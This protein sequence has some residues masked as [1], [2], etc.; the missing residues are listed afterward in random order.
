MEQGTLTSRSILSSFV[1]KSF[2][3]DYSKIKVLMLLGG[4]NGQYF[5][6]CQWEWSGHVFCASPIEVAS[7]FHLDV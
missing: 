1:G 3:K 2:D 7:K 5:F 6:L 4:L